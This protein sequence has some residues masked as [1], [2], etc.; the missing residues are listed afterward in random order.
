MAPIDLLAQPDSTDQLNKDETA[1]VE[2]GEE[3]DEAVPRW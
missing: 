3:T 2:G 1:S